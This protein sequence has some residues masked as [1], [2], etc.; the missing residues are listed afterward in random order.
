M[1]H[2]HSQRLAWHVEDILVGRGLAKPYYSIGG[3]RSLRVPQV[4]SVVDG[5]PVGV[6]IQMLPGQ[7]PDDFAAHA[8]AIAYNLGV[9][10]VRVVSVAPSLVRLELIPRSGH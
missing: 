10:E 9:A 6:E 1:H 3:G 8:S 2:E 7:T 4:V 5:P